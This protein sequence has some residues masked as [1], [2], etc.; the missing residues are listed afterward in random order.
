[1]L[2]P[3]KG[4]RNAAGRDFTRYKTEDDWSVSARVQTPFGGMQVGTGTD[5]AKAVSKSMEFRRYVRIDGANKTQAALAECLAVVWLTPQMDRLFI[6]ASSGRRRFMDRIIYGY[7]PAHAQLLQ[8]YE[9][10][11][12]D[13]SKLLRAE[14][15]EGR[16][17]DPIWVTML[18]KQMANLAVALCSNRLRVMGILEQICRDFKTPFPAPH[19]SVIGDVEQALQT[20]T[21]LEVEDWLRHVLLQA[22]GRDG[23]VGGASF[24]AHKSDLYVEH[25]AHGMPAELCST[26]EQKALLIGIVLAQAALIKK[27]RGVSPILLLDE[28]AAHLDRVRRDALLELLLSLSEQVWLTGTEIAPFENLKGQGYFLSVREGAITPA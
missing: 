5:R 28:I 4:L 14:Q 12:R 9:K 21:A 8:Q 18:E 25:P 3:G 11:M 27:E 16:S 6:E 1:M 2:A 20:K 26:G 13:R 7:D 24:G 17:Y 15:E 10:V 22:R 23:Q 19:L